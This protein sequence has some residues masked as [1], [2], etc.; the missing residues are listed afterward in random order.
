MQENHKTKLVLF[1]LDGTLIDTAPDFLVSLNNV[2]KNHDKSCV[3]MDEVRPHISEGTSKLIK[4]FFKIDESDKN[5][6]LYKNQF[7]SEYESNLKKNSCLFEGMTDLIKF[8]DKKSIKYG[9]VTNKHYKYAQPII[10]SFLELKN[11]KVLICPDHV[12][13]SKPDPE[14]ILLAC[15]KLDIK[16]ENT[17]YLGDH[18][19]DIKAGICA[20]AK[21][22]AC[23]YGYSINKNQI[24]N[25]RCGQVKK[26]NEIRSFIVI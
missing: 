3:S 8:L 5:F 14:G 19:N 7:L 21:T 6:N 23:L 4:L 17:I 11:V 26:V 22:V 20:G 10:D 1:D 25:M 15:K 2:L 16:P 18:L 12:N 13:I 24:D 9:V